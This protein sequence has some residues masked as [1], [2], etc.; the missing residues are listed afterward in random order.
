MS[1]DHS[2]TQHIDGLVQGDEEATRKIWERYVH[3]LIRLANAKLK[4]SPRKVFNEED[5]VQNSFENFFRQVQE[6]RF[7]QL[8]DR[9][10]LWQVL[11]MLVDRKA[12]DQIKHLNTQ[13]AGNR[14]VRGDSINDPANGGSPMI[15][16]APDF[17]PSPETAVEFVEHLQ[18]KLD[19]LPNND[20]RQI[21]LLKLEGYQDKEIAEKLDMP[22]RTVERRSSKFRK[23]WSTEQN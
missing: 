17:M 13:K 18:H 15:E 20:Y 12:K 9:N 19:E 11:A 6:G 5:V 4:N 22:L 8:D 23:S 3:Q 7:R 10:D 16:Q 21:V 14:Q 1:N 2:V